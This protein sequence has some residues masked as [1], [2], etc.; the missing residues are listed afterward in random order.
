M[1]HAWR[2]C[3]GEGIQ[4]AH[5]KHKRMEGAVAVA[6]QKHVALILIIELHIHMLLLNDFIS[7][8]S[9]IHNWTSRNHHYT[10]IHIRT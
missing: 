9:T 3:I 10:A 2:G 1:G 5:T 7:C 4:L 6:R 8:G